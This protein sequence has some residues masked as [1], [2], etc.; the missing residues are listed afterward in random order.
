MN[1]SLRAI[2]A[3]ASSLHER[4]TAPDLIT[5][6][7]AEHDEVV[8][9]RMHA[10]LAAAANG[11]RETFRRRLEWDGLNESSARHAVRVFGPP[12]GGT[13]NSPGRSLEF[14]L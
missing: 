3:K 13:P 4:L 12:K 14:E 1:E 9:A 10:W 7:D 2:A 5:I 8:E 11:D 6:L